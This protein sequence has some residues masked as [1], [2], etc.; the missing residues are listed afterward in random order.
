MFS[1]KDFGNIK[2]NWLFGV[3]D[4][5]GINGHY[6]SEHVKTYLPANIELL[7][8]LALM[9]ALK[10]HQVSDS[11]NSFPKEESYLLSQDKRKKYA[12]ISEGF[13]KTSYDL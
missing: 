8:Q 1:L 6:A 13:I 9:Q 3:C 5:H 12:V 2:N 7:D 4:G 11:N 10:S